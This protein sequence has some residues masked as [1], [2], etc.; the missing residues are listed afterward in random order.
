MSFES[1]VLNEINKAKEIEL[2]TILIVS[3]NL[4]FKILIIFSS[5]SNICENG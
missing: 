1:V 2:K 5:T 3:P 4:P